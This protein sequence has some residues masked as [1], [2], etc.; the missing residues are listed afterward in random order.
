MMLKITIADFLILLALLMIIVGSLLDWCDCGE[1]LPDEPVE[2]FDSEYQMLY[3]EIME[4]LH[5]VLKGDR[6]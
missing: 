3:D 1:R 2:A 6:K 5:K 4:E